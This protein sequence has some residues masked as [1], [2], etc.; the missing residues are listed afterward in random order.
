MKRFPRGPKPPA[1]KIPDIEV[2]ILGETEMAWKVAK[3]IGAPTCWLPK[4]QTRVQETYGKFAL[5]EL[6]DWLAKE[7]GLM[8]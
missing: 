1:V 3:D 7:K 8:P 5:V 6:P 2:L 4:S